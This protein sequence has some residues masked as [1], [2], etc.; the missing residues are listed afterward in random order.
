[1]LERGSLGWRQVREAETLFHLRKLSLQLCLMDLLQKLLSLER[2]ALSCHLLQFEVDM[3][4]RAEL[5]HDLHR[6]PLHM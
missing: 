6:Y 3:A 5:G 2:D 1:M 4:L